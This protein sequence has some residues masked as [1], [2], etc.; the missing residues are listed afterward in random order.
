MRTQ[1]NTEALPSATLPWR[2][3]YWQIVSKRDRTAD[4]SFYYSV[5]TTGVYCRPSCPGRLAKRE[6]VRFHQSCADAERAGFR[7]CKRC[8]PNGT[9]PSEEQARKVAG[10]CRIIEESTDIPT[11]EHLAEK[12]GV[13]PFHLHRVFKSATGVTPRSYAVALRSKR[14]RS[15]LLSGKE[16]ITEAIYAAG[17]NSN[18]RFYDQSQ[19]ILG[20]TPS[21]FRTGGEQEQIKF[22]VGQCS[23][24]AILVAQS[25]HGVCAI[26]LG[27][28]P[29]TLVCDLHR[30][31]P[32]AELIPG[33]Q[34]FEHTVATVIGCVERPSQALD[35][36]LD[37]RGTAFQQRVW[38]ALAEIPV[39]S[40]LSYTELADRIGLPK[41]VRAVAQ[42]CGANKLA[43]AIP[44]HR[45][46]RQ[47][48]ELA[49]YRWGI[50]RKRRLLQR[51]TEL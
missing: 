47:S 20:M 43:V 29:E 1:L 39:G 49:G 26:L 5:E 34:T 28:D 46:V 40:R 51:E 24:G 44:C 7:A 36:P 30:Q 11:L 3:E 41:S 8:N 50:E 9:S 12:V 31:F 23:L 27:D 15:R 16:T 6:N 25:Q 2:E 18:G 19:A 21:S 38:K 48:G 42:A 35:L 17:Y 22:A 45:I 14:V 37:I 32:K 10:V 33:D 4:G 13:T